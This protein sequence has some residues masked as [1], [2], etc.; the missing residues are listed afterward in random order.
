MAYRRQTC[1]TGRPHQFSAGRAFPSADSLG[2]PIR[3]RRIFPNTERGSRGARTGPDC[4]RRAPHPSPRFLGFRRR[5]CGREQHAYLVLK[6]HERGIPQARSTSR[7]NQSPARCWRLPRGRDVS[8]SRLRHHEGSATNSGVLERGICLGPAPR[9]AVA[10]RERGER[11]SGV[12]RKPGLENRH[13]QM[14]DR[15]VTPKADKT[16]QVQS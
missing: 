3:E 10:G 6:T 11:V 9:I 4:L 16:G 15:S 13:K 2:P 14:I 1:T 5:T 8:R 12:K 7:G